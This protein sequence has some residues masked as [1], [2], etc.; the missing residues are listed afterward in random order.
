MLRAG[1][2][3]GSPPS[4]HGASQIA[5]ILAEACPNELCVSPSEPRVNSAARSV[6]LIHLGAPGL[7]RVVVVEDDCFFPPGKWWFESIAGLGPIPSS[8]GG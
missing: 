6:R 7:S 8:T 5:P 1:V 3:S 4:G 2:D